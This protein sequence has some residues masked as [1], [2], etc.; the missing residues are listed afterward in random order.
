VLFNSIGGPAHWPQI[1]KKHADS[2]SDSTREQGGENGER[3][4]AF[5]PN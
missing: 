4:G 2:G 3:R 1:E 5:D